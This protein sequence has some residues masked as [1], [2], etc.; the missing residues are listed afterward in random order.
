MKCP[1]VVFHPDPV[2]VQVEV[3]H[4]TSDI[5]TLIV[6]Y[7]HQAEDAVVWYS[8]RPAAFRYSPKTAD[9]HPWCYPLHDWSVGDWPRFN[10]TNAA[11]CLVTE[12]DWATR[13]TVH[14]CGSDH[15]MVLF[16]E[17]L[18]NASRPDA[19]VTEYEREGEL[20]FRGVGPGSAEVTL[21]LPGSIGWDGLWPDE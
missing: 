8:T 2:A 17:L 5:K 11:D 12:K 10:L 1:S 7:E 3:T 16:A 6:E 9:R 21:F 15:G 13:D 18:L 4:P 14:C 19:T 20:G